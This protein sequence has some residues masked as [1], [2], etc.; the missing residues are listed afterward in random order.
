MVGKAYDKD[1]LPA[2][3]AF[4]Q[5]A[6]AIADRR[7]RP[8][9]LMTPLVGFDAVDGFG[10]VPAFAVAWRPAAFFCLA[11]RA[12]CAAAMRALPAALILPLMREAVACGVVAADFGAAPRTLAN[13]CSSDSI[14]SLS[15]TACFSCS[16]DGLLI[17]VVMA[18]F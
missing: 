12:R 16:R 2:L 7:A 15:A 8:A 11:Q 18:E 4:A 17:G 10:V 14:C 13:S 5:R 9:A 1:F 6:L 3:F